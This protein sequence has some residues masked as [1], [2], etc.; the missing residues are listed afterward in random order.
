VKRVGESLA[1]LF[2]LLGLFWAGRES[3]HGLGAFGEHWWCPFPLVMIAVGIAGFVTL[4]RLTT[5]GR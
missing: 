4:R 5:P 2:L 3:D 1:L